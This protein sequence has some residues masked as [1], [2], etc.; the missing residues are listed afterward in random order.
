MSR[1]MMRRN[2]RKESRQSMIREKYAIAIGAKKRIRRRCESRR[3]L[4][5][6]AIRKVKRRCSMLAPS[7]TAAGGA[8]QA[9]RLV[10][11]FVRFFVAPG[12]DAKGDF[13]L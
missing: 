7:R 11:G 2:F 13:V 1:G 9:S 3:S 8:A 4:E 5:A 10:I 6:N 12:A